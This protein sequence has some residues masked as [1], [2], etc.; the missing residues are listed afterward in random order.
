MRSSLIPNKF[1]KKR[2]FAQDH[3]HKCLLMDA[4][5]NR[6]GAAADYRSRLK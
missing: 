4:I 5:A 1:G 3:V 2:I 6:I